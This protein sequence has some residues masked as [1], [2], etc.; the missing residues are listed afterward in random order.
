M[1]FNQ[2]KTIVSTSVARTKFAVKQHSPEITLAVGIAG[3]IGSTI[4]ACKATTKLSTVLKAHELNVT[5]ANNL[6]A[7]GD[8]SVYSKDD[9]DKDLFIMTVQTGV[10]IAKLYAPA[11]ILGSLSIMSIMTSH[12]ILR[13]RAAAMAAAYTALDSEFKRYRKNVVDKYGE[14]A[15]KMLKHGLQEK[16]ITELSVNPETG[17][18]EENEKTVN[19]TE[20]DI[21]DVFSSDTAR[22]YSKSES[23]NELFLEGQQNILNDMLASRGYLYLNEVYE[24]LGMDPTRKGQVCGWIYYNDGANDNGDNYVDF[25]KQAISIVNK[26]GEQETAWIL[27]FNHDGI[28]LDDF[29]KKILG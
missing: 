6:L 27:D 2:I 16:T 1:K 23:Y 12:R 18:V 9:R 29:E 7:E 21:P 17:E 3:V 26:N 19:T 24:R 25:R 28:I 4:M 5:T 15:D 13:Q 22:G 20:D 8:D 14:E 11:L 10:E